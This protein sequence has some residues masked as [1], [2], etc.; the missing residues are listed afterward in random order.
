[1]QNARCL[2]NWDF[3]MEIPGNM[4]STQKQRSG[5]GKYI[6]YVDTGGTFS[7]A[8]IVSP[9]GT[10]VRGKAFTTPQRLQD[11][12]FGCIQDGAEKL[13]TS[14]QDVVARADVIGYGTTVGTNVVV[15]GMGAPK[16][17]LI[18]TKGHEDRTL[19][20]RLRAAGLTRRE[21]MHI[22]A[23]DKPAPIIPRKR[24][25]GVIERLDC[26]GQVVIPLR[27]EDVRQAVRKLLAEEVEGI[28]VALLWS[29][30]NPRHEQ[31]V[32]EIIREMAVGLPVSISSEVAPIIRDYPRTMSTIID[33]YIGRALRA[34]LKEISG[35]LKEQ[36]YTRPLLVMQ[37]VGGLARSEVV[38]P[39]TTLHS[40]PVGGLTGVDYLKALYGY[41]NAVG[42]DV[43]GTSFDVSISSA[44]GEEFLREPVVGRFEIANPM[45]EIV[46]I[47]AGGGTIARVDQ[48]TR[49]LMVGPESAGA[50]PGPA[51]Y[52][53]GG[54]EPTVTDADV[55]MGRIDPEYFWGG[56]RKLDREK[57][58]AAIKEKI[59]DPL[60]M[61][62]FAAAEGICQIIDGKMQA[63]LST[64]MATKGIDPK[65]YLLFAFGG[66]GPTHCAGYSAGLGFA[67]VIVCPYAAVFSAFGA[68]TA[69]VRH[70]YE[71]SPF[72]LLANLPYDKVRLRFNLE[73]LTSLEQISSA[74][75]ERFNAM[76]GELERKAGADMEAEGFLPREVTKKYEL[77]ARYGGQ[78]WEIRCPISTNRIGSVE[79]LRAIIRAF[80]E[81]YLTTYTREAMLPAGGVE[82]VSSAL[83]ASAAVPKPV[84]VKREYVGRDP[85]AALKGER[86][87]YFHGTWMG[88]PIY[89]MER[90]RVGNVVEGPAIVEGTDTTLVVS[91][92]CALTVDEYLNMAM[93]ER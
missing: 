86:E 42:S 32:R 35:G 75:I 43:G 26:K 52:G 64:T 2:L 36:G 4:D 49:S 16:L 81:A 93:E 83:V 77:L 19:I 88:S 73:Q 63:I 22:V 41:K 51:C 58:V 11:C 46:T 76:Y 38:E 33:L 79:D 10:F 72:I 65:D 85:K 60:G 6:I 50:A 30:L 39:A 14:L 17:G 90:L 84:I 1:M 31:R 67:K 15:T 56:K 53:L 12:F 71:A 54:T 59:A 66:A 69:D 92:G 70:R 48:V 82:I 74:A 47:G 20:M 34:L 55:V 13:G 23:A 8:V 40:G 44:R 80:E 9:D 37:A 5:A 28:A 68:S 62:V 78:L 29:F 7:D 24:I 3:K 27:E 21:A 45:R 18:T 57:A 61:S 91:P 87:V 89:S 25:E